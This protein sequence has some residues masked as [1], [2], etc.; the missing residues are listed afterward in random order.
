MNS[1]DLTTLIVD[2]INRLK[3]KGFGVGLKVQKENARNGTVLIE[4]DHI[5]LLKEVTEG[6]SKY[7]II[8]N[9][10]SITVYLGDKDLEYI[11][12]IMSEG[13]ETVEFDETP[14]L[15]TYLKN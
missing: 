6:S 3:R 7:K 12:S 5:R 11:Y 10:E 9:N 2:K 14:D 15:L 4:I 8:V 1:T 13:L